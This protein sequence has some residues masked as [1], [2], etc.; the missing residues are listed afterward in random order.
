[1]KAKKN[2]IWGS[3]VVALGVVLTGCSPNQQELF[4]AAMKMQ[5]VTSI[6]QHTAMTFKLTG[7]GFEPDV[8][9][10]V[11]TAA[12]FLN[13]AKLDLETKTS[14]NDQKTVGKSQVTMNLALQGMDINV[15]LW[16]DSDLSGDTP[17]VTE[18]IKLPQIAKTSFPQQYASKEYMVMNP[19]NM[20]K[21][22]LDMTKLIDFSKNFQASEV[23]FLTSYSKRFNSNVDTAANSTESIQTNDG[24]KLVRS[25]EIRLNDAQFKDFIRYTVNNVVQDKEALNF[26]KGFM[27]SM[28]EMSQ[29]PDQAK[30]LSELDQAFKDFDV[31]KQTEF[32]A[33]FNNV[34]DQLKD[35]TLLGDKGIELKYFIYNGYFIRESGTINFKVDLAQMNKFMDILNGRQSTET[36]KGTLDMVV[37]FNTDNSGIND[38]LE[39]QI[40]VVNDTNSFDY[41][42]FIKNITSKAK[43]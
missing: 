6:Q 21:S 42:E 39:I 2:L 14:G 4:N 22:E 15:P 35:V 40:P 38:P 3:L 34:M 25:Y 41:M 7:S 8:Q 5:N 36:A 17:K 12:M 31:N 26:A 43:N 27:G 18:I 30:S 32:L 1:M 29:T 16:V 19:F 10:Q 13:N 23:Q 24:I 37:N 20:N 28:L 33:K 11:D 9:Q